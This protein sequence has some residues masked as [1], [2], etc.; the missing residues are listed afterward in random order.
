MQKFY[1]NQHDVYI[2]SGSWKCSVS[3]SGAHYW[4]DVNI[5]DSKVRS[6][7][8]LRCKYCLVV[9]DIEVAVYQYRGGRLKKSDKGD[10]QLQPK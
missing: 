8:S 9:K 4:Q 10:K 1:P 3:P 7:K 6:C 2:Q 5:T